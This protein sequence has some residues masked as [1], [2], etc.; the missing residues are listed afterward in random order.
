[1]RSGCAARV[2]GQKP[3]HVFDAEPSRRAGMDGRFVLRPIS[4]ATKASFYQWLTPLD[5]E[6]WMERARV[7]DRLSGV[8]AA[9][10]R[11]GRIVQPDSCAAPV[12]QL[13]LSDWTKHVQSDRLCSESQACSEKR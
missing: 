7:R 4:E 5:C 3:R 1:M 6:I 13:D 11:V 10:R 12:G 2:R 9:G 8:P